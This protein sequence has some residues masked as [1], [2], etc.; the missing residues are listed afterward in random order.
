LLVTFG[1]VS[2]KFRM[3]TDLTHFYRRFKYGQDTLQRHTAIF[4]YCQVTKSNKRLVVIWG[5]EVTWSN[6][7]QDYHSN[8]SCGT[9]SSSR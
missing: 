5:G 4:T 6:L 9:S 7:W 1:I 8:M 2:P 3:R